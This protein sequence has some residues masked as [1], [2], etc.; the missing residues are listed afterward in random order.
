MKATPLYE[1]RDKE[2]P[3]QKLSGYMVFPVIVL[4]AFILGGMNSWINYLDGSNQTAF[5]YVRIMLVILLAVV[6]SHA[7][8][9]F[10][11]DFIH[12]GLRGRVYTGS[13]QLRCSFSTWVVLVEEL[14]GVSATD[15][16]VFP[17]FRITGR[18]TN[19]FRMVTGWDGFITSK[20]NKG[21]VLETA[22]GK[23]IFSCDN[24]GEAASK[25]SELLNVGVKPIVLPNISIN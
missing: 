17:H 6:F 22:R 12:V 13:V 19:T 21:L 18:I 25:I 1:F 8:R 11:I 9:I 3:M 10:E 16:A 20:S 14:I 7:W 5:D 2:S 15:E 23:L 4:L 24:P